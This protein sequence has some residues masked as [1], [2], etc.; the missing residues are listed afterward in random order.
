MKRETKKDLDNKIDMFFLSE[1]DY[2][3]CFDYEFNFNNCKN[4]KEMNPKKIEKII[5]KYKKNILKKR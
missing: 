4:S 5:Q 2:N 1:K 3:F